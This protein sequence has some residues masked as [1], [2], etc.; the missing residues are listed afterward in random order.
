VPIS[1]ITIV[2]AHEPPW[3]DV[4]RELFAEYGRSIA[5]V[6]ACSL[7]HQGF[8][9]E[10]S[11][12]PGKYAPPPRGRGCMLLALDGAEVCGCIAL[13]PEPSVGPDVCEMK[14]MYVR[15]THRRSGTGRLLAG[16]VLAQALLLEY[17]SM[18]LDTAK[19]MLPAIALYRSLGF[20][21]RERYNGDPD[22]DTIWMTLAL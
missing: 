17:R 21:E 14:R 3:L 18:V 10:L 19:V 11:G 5:N 16:A 13:R 1:T 2:E 6:A 4:A 9:T 22:P 20:V 8:D 15:P 7:R 12:L